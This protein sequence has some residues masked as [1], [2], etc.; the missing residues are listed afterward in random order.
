MTRR[1]KTHIRLGVRSVSP[2]DQSPRSPHDLR[3]LG[4]YREISRCFF[5]KS[6]EVCPRNVEE[7]LR[8]LSRTFSAKF[9]G[10]NPRR[11]K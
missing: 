10:E 1:V 8:E 11:K 4:N 7:F 9:R 3:F 6:R 2:S 5:A